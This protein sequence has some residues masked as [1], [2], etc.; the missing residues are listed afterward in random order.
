MTRRLIL[1][2]AA[3]LIAV[4]LFLPTG[5]SATNCGKYLGSKIVTH[6]GLSC[7]RAKAIY[8]KFH[9]G[10]KVPSGWVCGLSAGACNKGS[11]GFTFRF[12]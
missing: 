5:A 6:G 9:A 12:N 4:A 8:R 1:L 3:A 7:S 11:K 2:A 10:E